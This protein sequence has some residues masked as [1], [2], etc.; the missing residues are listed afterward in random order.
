[1]VAIFDLCK[2]VILN[3]WLVGY[4]VMDLRPKFKIHIRESKKFFQNQVVSFE[5]VVIASIPQSAHHATMDSNYE[6]E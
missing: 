5:N 4:F 1:M 3:S 2:K 6:S